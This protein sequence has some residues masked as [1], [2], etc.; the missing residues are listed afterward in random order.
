MKFL[1]AACLAVLVHPSTFAGEA[2]PAVDVGDWSKANERVHEVGGWKAYAREIESS[3]AAPLQ[4]Q[5]QGS[6]TALFLDE[7]IERAMALEPSLRSTLANVSR[8]PKDYPLLSDHQRS[9][10]TQ[11]SR[12]VADIR[13]LYFAA[14]VAKERV[15]YQAQV[16]ETAAIVSELATRMRKVGNLNLL[17]QTEE[18]LSLA[19]TQRH[20]SQARLHAATSLEALARRLQHGGDPNS[21]HLPS[22]LPELPKQ[23]AEMSSV[24]QNLLKSPSSH[25][26]VLQA[27]S[28]VRLA[29]VAR[30][31]AYAS[32]RHYRDEILPLQRR[33]SEEHLLHYNGMIKGV[34]DL[35]KDARHQIQA[36]E[37]YLQALHSYWH[38]EAALEP[39][40]AA[41]REQLSQLRRDAWK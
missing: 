32:A 13:A 25:P 36:V 22:R 28:E 16:V 19:K 8:H 1:F 27:Q 21:L 38:S 12:L 15:N 6:Q 23:L 3:Q 41:L 5:A 11:E 20:L 24:D 9:A 26:S 35:L 33:L 31:E 39:K 10:L 2:S 18:Q 29:L 30:D 34:F 4:T 37:G 7:A 14:V 17:H 40:L